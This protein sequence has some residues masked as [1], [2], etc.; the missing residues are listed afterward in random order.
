MQVAAQP[1]FGSQVTCGVCKTSFT[2]NPSLLITMGDRSVT[3]PTNTDDPQ[4]SP[5]DMTED[6][7]ADVTDINDSQGESDLTQYVG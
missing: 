7:P 4:E 6:P 1:D 2:K 3:S 5:S